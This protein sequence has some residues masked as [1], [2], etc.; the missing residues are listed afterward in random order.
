M[1]DTS[2]NNYLARTWDK[3]LPPIRPYFEELSVFKYYIQQYL[4]NNSTK[5]E[6]LILGSTPEL[7]DVVYEFEIIPTV[8]DFSV[9]NYTG[10]SLL[11]RMRGE[12]SFVEKNWL[13]L[14][15]KDGRFDFIFSEAA[16]NV[17]PK[18]SA[19][20]MYRIASELLKNNGLIISK[21]WIRFSNKPY[22]IEHLVEKY[23]NSINT[24]G[25]YSFICIPLMLIFYDYKNERITL[26]DLDNGAQGLLRAGLITQ[27]EYETIGI[28]EYQNVELE[29]YIPEI[30]EFEKDMKEYLDL[31]CIHNMNTAFSEYHPI[32]VYE[33]K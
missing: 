23:R 20:K 28:H 6:I 27:K 7:R 19:K 12:D 14:T 4:K 15:D 9:E 29:L 33:R 2:W 10:M 24:Y 3:Y 13:D 25:F 5:P 17:L 1:N 18:A 26:K 16:F 22:T 31:L 21:E 30:Y 32:F 8:V 11:R